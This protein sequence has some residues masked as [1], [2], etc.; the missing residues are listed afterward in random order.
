MYLRI[1]SAVGQIWAFLTGSIAAVM[2]YI[3]TLQLVQ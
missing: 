2:A 3:K 1:L